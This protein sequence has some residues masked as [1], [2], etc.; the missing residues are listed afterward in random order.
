[1][2]NMFNGTKVF[3]HS[4]IFSLII[5]FGIA[6]TTAGPSGIFG[7]KS[8]HDAYGD[9]I[10]NAGLTETALGKQWFTAG[11]KSLAAPLSI[12]IP[13]S[14]TGYFSA[15]E[16][17]A[18]GF[19]FHARRGEKLT[20]NL[21]KKPAAGFALY[22]DLWQPAISTNANPT[23]LLS[24]DSIAATVQ[25]DADKDGS[26]ILRLQPELL[27]SGEYTL[28][29]STG[30]SLA[31]PVTP[32]VKSN[33]GSFWGAGR[34]EGARKHEGIDIFAPRGTALVA[35]ANG[36]VNRV[37]ENRLG[38]RVIFLSPDNKDYTL[39][40]AHLE[41]QIATQGQR[42]KTGDTIGLMGNTGNAITT[43]P[44]LH[45][46]IYTYSGAI[47][48]LPFVNRVNK[49]PE[50]VSAPVSNINKLVRNNKTINLSGEPQSGNVV[51]V[52]EPN[53]L[54][55]A[56]AATA[57]WY[58]VLL[59]GGEQGFIAAG[60]VSIATNPIKK[61]GLKNGQALLDAPD[62]A[63]LHKMILAAGQLVSILASYKDFYFV[64]HDNDRGWIPKKSF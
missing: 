33:I 31:F 57:G 2:V 45:F 3:L 59:P 56:E 25:Y 39:Y 42:V 46:G 44:H 9:K 18:V 8:P 7:K 54:L 26:Y 51:A 13:Y 16:P 36:T 24:G 53:T 52:L 28:T 14:E 17:K 21:N 37:E 35:A 30:P 22:L 20:I 23:L 12:N 15:A 40:Y 29:I 10:K 63:A 38:G 11:E 4:F 27:K 32:K 19:I 1:M 60:N 50:R 47:D 61:A 41:K 64:E 43:V 6:C 55:K 62:S 34:D 5:L 58:R 49:M 48:P